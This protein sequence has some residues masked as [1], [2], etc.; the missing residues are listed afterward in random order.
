MSWCRYPWCCSPQN[1]HV[2]LWR[3][4][5]TTG[6]NKPRPYRN[7]VTEVQKEVNGKKKNFRFEI[8]EMDREYSHRVW[9]DRSHREHWDSICIELLHCKLFPLRREIDLPY[10]TNNKVLLLPREEQSLSQLW[11]ATISSF[12]FQSLCSESTVRLMWSANKKFTSSTYSMSRDQQHL[13][14]I[15]EI[16]TIIVF[17]LH[18]CF[19]EIKHHFCGKISSVDASCALQMHLGRNTFILMLYKHFM[20]LTSQ[21]ISQ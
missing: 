10:R 20:N 13:I 5:C 21:D 6:P 12:W 1:D 19:I 16:L 7:Y 17:K 8:H 3:G 4:M 18:C 11:A 2:E 15:D 14:D 9:E